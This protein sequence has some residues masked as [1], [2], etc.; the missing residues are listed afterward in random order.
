MGNDFSAAEGPYFTGLIEIINPG[1][2]Q[3][4]RRFRGKKYPFTKT[5][6]PRPARVTRIFA[7]MVASFNLSDASA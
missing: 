6:R 1:T 7:V 3:A 4:P 5:M 2:D